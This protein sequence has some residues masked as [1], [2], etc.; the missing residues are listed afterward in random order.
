[1][2]FI[3]SPALA[4]HNRNTEVEETISPGPTYVTYPDRIIYNLYETEGRLIKQ[5]STRNPKER[6]WVWE[7]YTPTVPRY[8][9]LFWD[10][11]S[12]QEHIRVE[13][14]DSPYVYLK[15]DVT[16]F[17]GAYDDITGK[18]DGDWV[19]CRIFLVDRTPADRG[20]LI[21]YGSTE[22]RFTYDDPGLGDIV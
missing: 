10:L 19:R 21:R 2:A 17:W 5:R 18:Y 9:D 3:Y 16:G 6:T 12:L 8:E 22:V 7:N 20:G 11:F 14:G 15:E 13:N 1:M 4:N